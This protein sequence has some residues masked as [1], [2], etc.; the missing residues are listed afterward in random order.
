MS[1]LT[2]SLYVAGQ[3][4]KQRLAVA[5]SLAPTDQKI[6]G[7]SAKLS[8][9]FDP[10]SS[11]T[12]SSKISLLESSTPTPKV[13]FEQ[14]NDPD[15]PVNCEALYQYFV[16]HPGMHS[17]MMVFNQE[18]QL[19][20]LDQIKK[21]SD[22]TALVE[23]HTGCNMRIG[24]E[25]G[26]TGEKKR[27]EYL[28]KT[29]CNYQCHGF[30]ADLRYGR[31]LV[32]EE[33]KTIFIITR[34][35]IRIQRDF[36]E[37]I[38]SFTARLSL[39]PEI[40]VTHP[41]PIQ[42]KEEFKQQLGRGIIS[43]EM[44][45]RT[46]KGVAELTQD[47]MTFIFDLPEMGAKSFAVS[48]L[49]IIIALCMCG[50][51]DRDTIKSIRLGHL[52]PDLLHLVMGAFLKTCSP[53]ED[54]QNIFHLFQMIASATPTASFVEL[55]KEGKK[56]YNATTITS[57][58]T[59]EVV[60]AVNAFISKKTQGVTQ[61][62]IQ[63]YVRNC[64]FNGSLTQFFYKEEIPQELTQY[65][66]FTDLTGQKHLSTMMHTKVLHLFH[67]GS[68]IADKLKFRIVELPLHDGYSQLLIQPDDFSE[69]QQLGKKIGHE[70]IECHLKY[71]RKMMTRIKL[72]RTSMSDKFNING[73][74]REKIG[75]FLNENTVIHTSVSNTCSEKKAKKILP[76]EQVAQFPFVG[77]TIFN[78]PH[79]RV[80][81]NE[82]GLILMI[83]SIC[84]PD[85]LDLSEKI[86][87]PWQ[88]YIPSVNFEELLS[89]EIPLDSCTLYQYIVE[90]PESKFT[91]FNRAG[92]EIA[93]SEVRNPYDIIA[94]FED[95]TKEQ[96][97]TVAYNG[98]DEENKRHNYALSIA[99]FEDLDFQFHD[100]RYALFVDE[101]EGVLI[102]ERDSN[103]VEITLRTKN[104]TEVPIWITE[105][106]LPTSIPVVFNIPM[107]P[108]AEVF[109]SLRQACLAYL[110]KMFGIHRLGENIVQVPWKSYVPNVDFDGLLSPETPVNSQALF[111]YIWGNP[112]S[113]FII[114]NRNGEKI[115]PS[116]IKDPADIISVFEDRTKAG[117]VS[118]TYRTKKS[119]D[120]YHEYD[121][122]V[123]NKARGYYDTRYALFVDDAEGILIFERD[124]DNITITLQVE[125]ND[126]VPSWL[127]EHKLPESISVRYVAMNSHFKITAEPDLV[128]V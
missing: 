108:N 49:S 32:N 51:L 88:P 28:I 115:Q 59:R 17:Y 3:E 43:E 53:K 97:V 61:E 123:N 20:P 46:V 65:H 23:D 60:N 100:S 126:T 27:Y 73:F 79:Y 36:T 82:K 45:Q 25:R 69:Y 101:A 66:L 11:A 18:G 102:L 8:Q 22:I 71:R 56:Y 1:P 55:M 37:I 90:H 21:P 85:S 63:G 6:T 120:K 7:V 109:K 24:L 5:P 42:A 127:T 121:C 72:P 91:V 81:I 105:N 47:V 40:P 68:D 99:S 58:D 114:F 118:I 119:D 117:C 111:Q 76:S 92:Q 2:L 96:K 112:N 15:F 106:Q 67:S 89:P 33:R 64:I 29:K 10:N 70:M 48:P 44:M 41:I 78:K 39:N 107:N 16:S 74:F 86:S 52:E 14:L 93:P 80:Y 84:G 83:E 125:D 57:S 38:S 54:A 103:N 34:N 94:V 35:T 122:L 9:P 98:W 113:K 87:M 26:S 116:E 13:N 4:P 75:V 110:K 124:S 128:L 77:T 19:V 104:T 12:L 50:P 30:S 31:F 95:R 62:A